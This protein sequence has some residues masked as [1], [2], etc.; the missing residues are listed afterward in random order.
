MAKTDAEIG[1][2]VRAAI[3]AVDTGDNGSVVRATIS[4]GVEIE[5][6]EAKTLSNK[7]A[8]PQILVRY[9]TD[10]EDIVSR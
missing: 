7:G 5:D 10:T 3:A 4:I 2:A 1:A 9:N 6:S 8:A